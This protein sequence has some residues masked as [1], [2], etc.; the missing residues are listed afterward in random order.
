MSFIIAYFNNKKMLRRD[1]VFL[2]KM[3]KKYLDKINK[4]KGVTDE[5]IAFLSRE[6]LTIAQLKIA[7][8]YIT[9]N[10]NKHDMAAI[11][12]ELELYI[13][14]P[15]TN[16][17]LPSCSEDLLMGNSEGKTLIYDAYNKLQVLGC[18]DMFFSVDICEILIH[19]ISNN[20]SSEKIK[21][22]I[23]MF[24]D[25][26]NI[27]KNYSFLECFKTD[28]KNYIDKSIFYR[29]YKDQRIS[30][31]TF[32][33]FHLVMD[34]PLFVTLSDS[35]KDRLYTD[36]VSDNNLISSFD[37][38]PYSMPPVVYNV[39]TEFEKNLKKYIVENGI[40]VT[41]SKTSCKGYI[42]DEATDHLTKR[43]RS[44]LE[45]D[46]QIK[47]E[48]S[49]IS[50]S[51]SYNEYYT[52][53][54]V[55]RFKNISL[56]KRRQYYNDQSTLVSF[57]IYPDGSIMQKNGRS[58]YPLSIKQ[59]YKNIVCRQILELFLDACCNSGVYF[60]RD[61]RNDTKSTNAL[62]TIVL[63]D[64]FKYHNRREYLAKY[65]ADNYEQVNWNKVNIHKAYYI[66]K[67][68]RYV[69]PEDQNRLIS[70][71]YS[72][73]I[74]TCFYGG[75]IKNQIAVFLCD[76]IYYRLCN[77]KAFIIDVYEGIETTLHPEEVQEEVEDTKERIKRLIKDTLIMKFTAKE[78]MKISIK[79]YSELQNIHD[80]ISKNIDY[81]EKTGSVNIP[82]PSVFNKLNKMLPSDF[83][84]IKTRK[85]LI[86]ETRIQHH[87]VWSYAPKI[88][89]DKCAIY[90]YYDGN[91]EY[92][93]TPKR[94]TI[95]FMRKSNGRYYVEQ[96]QGRYDKASSNKL[97]VYLQ[98]YLEK[99]QK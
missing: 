61:I 11:I 33:N 55:K 17:F 39:V 38:R 12:K 68:L 76:V 32:S 82:S 48:R 64:L 25:T 95:E 5:A 36:V 45:D 71:A 3:Q 27:F 9:A 53:I 98:N 22:W 13:D 92:G 65:G 91:S 62:C 42:V 40:D 7:Y 19:F 58:V 88:T 54:V 56:D 97:Y 94:Y 86:D 79:S 28:I 67:S 52:N 34:S 50:V 43:I 78:K 66:L 63:N 87:C 29:L 31:V 59:L 72:D 49:G 84:W 24:C 93:D 99:T 6:D 47:I 2:R 57:A 73:F 44:I 41:T 20:M 60:A 81:E 83:E 35:A 51:L 16:I 96:V 46:T 69:I 26:A 1:V 74:P 15:G 80:E 23:S 14:A 4:Y 75:R 8:D 10:I 77:D 18:E 85:R 37:I 70:Y 21:E 30:D 89:S 90:S